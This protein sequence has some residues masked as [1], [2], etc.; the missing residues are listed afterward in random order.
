MKNILIIQLNRLGDIVITLPLI[1]TLNLRFNDCRITLVCYKQFSRIVS[2]SPA[3]RW[4]HRFVQADAQNPDMLF[5]FD[6]ITGSEDSPF[7]ELFEE[8]DIAINLVYGDRPAAFFSKIRAESK[9][10]QLGT[11]H[12]EIR[13]AGDWPRYLYSFIPYREYNL[14]N[15]TDLFTRYS[16][17]PNKKFT[18][19]LDF[20]PQ[21][22]DRA[23][24]ILKE[25]SF[26]GG[27]LVAFQLGA[28]EALRRW[29]L[30]KFAELGHLLKE[31]NNGIEIV[32]IGSEDEASLTARFLDSVRYPVVNLV[33]K[34]GLLE[35]P[36]VLS[37]CR[38]LVSNDTGPIHV[39]SAVGT[40][41]LG[42]YF[43]AAYYAE[44]GPY[45]E[46]NMVVQSE[47][48]CHPC[49]NYYQCSHKKCR[50]L[51]TAKMVFMAASALLDDNYDNELHAPDVSIYRSRFM[52]NGSLIYLPVLAPA[53]KPLSPKFEKGLI[54]RIMWEK[55]EDVP[56]YIDMIE[57][58]LPEFWGSDNVK[59][60]LTAFTSELRNMKEIFT[61]G[62]AACRELTNQYS[63]P[64]GPDKGAV[65]KPLRT[66]NIIESFI[67]KREEPLSPLKLYFSFEMM[68]VG[69]L[70]FPALGEELQKKYLKLH[71]MAD[72]FL[73]NLESLIVKSQSLMVNK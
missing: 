35:L 33:G 51:I 41:T 32:L 18:N 71:G 6:K 50:P 61:F 68:E 43:L 69:Y 31:K 58:E 1:I 39:A 64:G 36:A 15:M 53:D 59:S 48:E 26:N 29:D 52:A 17:S 70:Q 25:N 60:I 7:P 40:Q 3:G 34:T 63:K 47:P 8:Y 14:F 62:A 57:K 9:F 66:L 46:G 38:L 19:Y 54:Y 10:G 13:L 37:R 20:D 21:L 16:G 24:A 73:L 5:N 22:E 30:E 2:D 11:P 12:E 45:G 67:D 72:R 55:K 49:T 4:I 42:I 27:I 28:S 44:T 65:S 56:A 23:E